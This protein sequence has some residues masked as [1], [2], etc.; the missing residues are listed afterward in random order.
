M[1]VD[2]VNV[3]VKAGDGGNGIVSFRKEK[4]IDRGGPDGGDGGKGGDII[5]VAENNMDTLAVY[6]NHKLQKAQNGESGSKRKKHGKNGNNLVLNVPVGTIIYDLDGK[7]IVDLSTKKSSFVIAAGGS[8]GF[9]NA[10]F[11]SSVRQAPRVAERGEKGEEKELVFEL[12]LVADVGLVGLPNAGKS[13]LLGSLSNARPEIADYPFTTL[14]PNLGVVDYSDTSLLLADVPGLIEGAS[15]GKG[16]GDEFLKHIERTAVIAHLIDIYD[17]DVLESYKTIRNELEDYSKN[18]SK[19][20]SIIVLNK[21][22][23]LDKEIIDQQVK[24]IQK[25]A[26][27]K[28]KVIAISANAKIGL[29]DLLTNLSKLVK[30]DR[31]KVEKQKTKKRLKIIKYIPKST[32]WTIEKVQE[33]YVVHGEKIL[34]FAARTDFNNPAGIRRLKDIMKKTGIHNQLKRMGANPND[35]VYFGSNNSEFIEF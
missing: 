29:N 15:K 16:L 7:Q 9:G 4:Y 11:V 30:A 20:P 33:D 14:I 17:V 25:A 10:H 31:M 6:R 8:G 1:F 19:K 28:T 32:D 18:L 23:G 24:L 22:E 35:K 34:K 21:I 3:K 12:K 27:K 13:T 2:K 5:V 26:G